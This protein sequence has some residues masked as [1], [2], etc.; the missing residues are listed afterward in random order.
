MLLTRT[1]LRSSATALAALFLPAA[2]A[3]AWLLPLVRETASH[4][5][6]SAELERALTKYA[7]ELNVDSLHHYALRPE[8]VSRGG[9][10]AVAALVVVPLA[11]FAPRQRWARGKTAWSPAAAKTP[12]RHSVAMSAPLVSRR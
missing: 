1:D 4:S 8:V 2:A 10:V 11:A 9:A 12:T 6:S 7:A 5:P 3:L